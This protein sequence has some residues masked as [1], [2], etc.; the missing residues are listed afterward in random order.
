MESMS[1]TDLSKIKL[2]FRTNVKFLAVDLTSLAI[3]SF[4]LSIM[5]PM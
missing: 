2:L 5:K 1:M 4:S 3:S